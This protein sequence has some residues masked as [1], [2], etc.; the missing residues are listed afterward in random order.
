MRYETVAGGSIQLFFA[1]RNAPS[2]MSLVPNLLHDCPQLGWRRVRL[3]EQ[4]PS[5][6]TVHFEEILPYVLFG[7]NPASKALG[8]VPKTIAGATRK[9]VSGRQEGHA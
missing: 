6:N 3:S 2:L 5:V 1:W 9:R 8:P 7:A 4:V